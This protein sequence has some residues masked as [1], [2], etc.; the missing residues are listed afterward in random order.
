MLF[1]LTKNEKTNINNFFDRSFKIALI[2]FLITGATGSI[3]ALADVIFPSETFLK[4][5]LEDFDPNSELLTRL[6]ILHPIT[7]SFL[8][9]YFY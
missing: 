3:T 5:F 6:R 7:A 4:V 8:S 2:L 9:I 1:Y